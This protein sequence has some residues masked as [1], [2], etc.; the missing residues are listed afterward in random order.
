MR[1]PHQRWKEKSQNI[2]ESHAEKSEEKTVIDVEVFHF[3]V[4]GR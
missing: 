2:G 3:L 4:G 1:N